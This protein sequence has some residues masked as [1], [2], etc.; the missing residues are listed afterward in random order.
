MN[1]LFE[2]AFDVTTGKLF[3]FHE[4]P[5]NLALLLRGWTSSPTRVAS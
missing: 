3:A 4:N 1:L 5:N 2:H